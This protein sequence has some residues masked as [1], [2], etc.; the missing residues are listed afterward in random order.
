MDNLVEITNHELFNIIKKR[1]E[2]AKEGGKREEAIIKI[3]ASQKKMQNYQDG[4]TE[5][6]HYLGPMGPYEDYKITF[7][8][9]KEK[10]APEDSYCL[11]VEKVNTKK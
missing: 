5:E 3:R 2:K 10:N 6:R 4:M 11:K 9:D 1:L 7:Y 8:K